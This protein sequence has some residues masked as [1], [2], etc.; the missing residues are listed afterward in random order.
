[1]NQPR[2][3]RKQAREVKRAIKHLTYRSKEGEKEKARR[4]QQMV[5]E[6]LKADNGVVQQWEAPDYTKPLDMSEFYECDNA[7]CDNAVKAPGLCSTCAKVAEHL[8]SVT[9]DQSNG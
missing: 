6:T 2:M 5:H 8:I 7:D 1:M 9:E 3:T 4:V